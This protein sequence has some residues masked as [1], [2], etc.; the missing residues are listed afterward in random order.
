MIARGGKIL[1]SG[2]G[3]FEVKHISPSEICA[4]SRAETWAILGDGRVAVA[5]RTMT[6]RDIRNVDTL[7]QTARLAIQC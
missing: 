4:S 1:E 7:K 6:D 3:F 2:K 5:A